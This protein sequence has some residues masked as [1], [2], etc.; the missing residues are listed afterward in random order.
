MSIED[1][2]PSLSGFCTSVVTLRGSQMNRTKHFLGN[3]LTVQMRSSC[4]ILTSYFAETKMQP[5]V[6][7]LCGVWLL[8]AEI[9]S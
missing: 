1:A 4:P 7:L 3:A 9:S 2:V 5:I 6:T 8:H